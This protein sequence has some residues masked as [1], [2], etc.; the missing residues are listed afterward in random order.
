MCRISSRNGPHGTERS[1]PTADD[2]NPLLALA[3]ERRYPAAREGLLS[4][5]VLPEDRSPEFDF[6]PLLLSFLFRRHLVPGRGSGIAARAYATLLLC[7]VS[8]LGTVSNLLVCLIYDRD[9]RCAHGSNPCC[10]ACL[11]NARPDNCTR[12]GRSEKPMSVWGHREPWASELLANSDALILM[13]G[14]CAGAQR[15][16]HH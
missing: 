14:W 12:S 1:P 16:R 9:L 7:P 3:L 10:L 11:T 2:G 6:N 8:R 5:D 13:A 15:T 4:L